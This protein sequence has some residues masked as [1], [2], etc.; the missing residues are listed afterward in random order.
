MYQFHKH[1]TLAR[2]AR[3]RLKY[4]SEA[5]RFARASCQKSRRGGA[6]RGLQLIAGQ[7]IAWNRSARFNYCG[8]WGLKISIAVFLLSNCP[9]NIATWTI[10][11]HVCLGDGAVCLPVWRS[12]VWRV[13]GASCDGVFMSYH[14]I[15]SYAP[16]FYILE[17]VD[18][19]CSG[20]DTC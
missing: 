2:E 9:I 3:N 17:Q 5:A 10:L 18:S 12:A 1:V 6:L 13:E 20:N 14:I 7:V 15:D 11:A 4:W 8:H 19:R 16:V